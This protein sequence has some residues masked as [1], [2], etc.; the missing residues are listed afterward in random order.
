MKFKFLSIDN[1]FEEVRDEA[2]YIKFKELKITNDKVKIN[3][4]LRRTIFESGLKEIGFKVIDSYFTQAVLSE[5]NINP[6]SLS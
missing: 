5:L 6:S 4:N 1:I 3:P 2:V